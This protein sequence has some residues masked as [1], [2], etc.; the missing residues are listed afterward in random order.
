MDL[1]FRRRNAT[2]WWHLSRTSSRSLQQSELRY[3]WVCVRLETIDCDEF[4]ELVV[5]AWRMCA[6]EGRGLLRRSRSARSSTRTSSPRML[7][8]DEREDEA[9][10][11]GVPLPQPATPSVWGIL[12]FVDLCDDTKGRALIDQPGVE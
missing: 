1:R 7:H 8:R 3:N 6:Q 12:R 11:G 10:G 9:A 4:R 2:R 5:D